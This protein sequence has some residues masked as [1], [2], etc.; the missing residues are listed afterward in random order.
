MPI[1]GDHRVK[2]FPPF[3]DSYSIAEASCRAETTIAL[4]VTRPVA[5]LIFSLTTEKCL[6]VVVFFHEG[7]VFSVKISHI[8]IMFI[9][10]KASLTNRFINGLK[11]L[12]NYV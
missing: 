8:E 7:L 3:H 1:C 11:K 4:S 2:A 9:F 6:K 10:I 5:T 12:C